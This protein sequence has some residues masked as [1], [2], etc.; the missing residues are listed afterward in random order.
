MTT[1][2]YQLAPLEKQ[3]N[4]TQVSATAPV[5]PFPTPDDTP[6]NDPESPAPAEQPQPEAVPDSEPDDLP[7]VARGKQDLLLDE[8]AERA[9]VISEAE[10]R[11]T[12]LPKR[13][14]IELTTQGGVCTATY[15]TG[16]PTDPR[17]EAIARAEAA[18]KVRRQQ[19]FNVKQWLDSSYDMDVKRAKGDVNKT[20]SPAGRLCDL[21]AASVLRSQLAAVREDRARY[22]QLYLDARDQGSVWKKDADTFMTLFF[23][24]GAIACALGFVVFFGGAL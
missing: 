5:V 7:M 21:N 3:T 6:A 19:K 9:A 12:I 13:V 10:R 24:M 17:D 2:A 4:T 20:T 8:C 22:V 16:Y 11:L 1:A 15:T 14:D 23:V 18:I